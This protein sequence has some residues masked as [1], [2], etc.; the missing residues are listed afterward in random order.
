MSE[1]TQLEIVKNLIDELILT[2]KQNRDLSIALAVALVN[3]KS[4]DRLEIQKAQAQA[5]SFYAQYENALKKNEELQSK[6][7][8]EI[9]EENKVKSMYEIY[10]T[11]SYEVENSEQFV[12]PENQIIDEVAT[13]DIDPEV[14]EIISEWSNQTDSKT[15]TE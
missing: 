5:Q 3:P 2:K 13:E 11:Q 6:L 4:T 7:N 1:V 8:E 10:I 14:N 15:V 9:D 12:E